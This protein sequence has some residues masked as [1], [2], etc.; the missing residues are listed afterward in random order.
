VRIDILQS[1][2]SPRTRAWVELLGAIV[3]LVPFCLAVL[4]YGWNFVVRSFLMNEASASQTGLPYRWIIKSFLLAGF[5]LLLVSA[6]G[7]IARQI[8][9]LRGEPQPAAASIGTSPP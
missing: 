4:W 9:I 2:W 1:R 8:A 5:A 6:I 3:F 7:S